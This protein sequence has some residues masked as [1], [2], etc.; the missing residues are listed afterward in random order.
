[1]AV[2]ATKI[3]QD[4]TRADNLINDAM[5]LSRYL[6]EIEAGREV[7]N[8]QGHRPRGL[9]DGEAAR[10]RRLEHEIRK[11]RKSLKKLTVRVYG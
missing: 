1:M 7:R 6:F 3:Q 9:K 5:R 4:K 10:V 11:L 8:R 2:N